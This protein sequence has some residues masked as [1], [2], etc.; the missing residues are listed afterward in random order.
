MSFLTPLAYKTSIKG[1]SCVSDLR[2]IMITRR[3]KISNAVHIFLDVLKQSKN[4]KQKKNMF[5]ELVPDVIVGLQLPGNYIQRDSLDQRRDADFVPSRG[6]PATR[7][8]MSDAH[9]RKTT[10]PFWPLQPIFQRGVFDKTAR[11]EGKA[12][13][14]MEAPPKKTIFCCICQPME[15]AQSLGD[16]TNA[17]PNGG[18]RVQCR[19]VSPFASLGGK[20]C[21]SNKD[22]GRRERKNPAFQQQMTVGL[23][24]VF[25]TTY[26]GKRRKSNFSGFAPYPKHP[27]GTI[28]FVCVRALCVLCMSLVGCRNTQEI[29]TCDILWFLTVTRTSFSG[30]SEVQRRPQWTCQVLLAP[31][32]WSVVPQEAQA[33]FSSYAQAW[34]FFPLQPTSFLTHLGGWLVSS[35]GLPI[36]ATSCYRE[37]ATSRGGGQKAEIWTVSAVAGGKAIEKERKKM[38]REEWE[39]ERILLPPS[40]PS[41]P[42]L[43]KLTPSPL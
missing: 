23:F 25:Q 36:F 43:P 10:V 28:T 26:E 35:A 21:P 18:I 11:T 40:L 24:L 17:V 32:E 5:L 6:R 39:Q 4:A 7:E 42:V 30:G 27:F 16:D 2:L 1:V 29:N 33:F 41:L 3:I 8:T 19:G 20:P 37:I 15:T 22:A 14:V 12:R 9:S 34:S 38:Q 13:W 31:H